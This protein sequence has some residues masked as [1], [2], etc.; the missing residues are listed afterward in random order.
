M[1]F[2]CTFDESHL[3]IVVTG[4]TLIVDAEL[5]EKPVKRTRV[6]GDWR[7]LLKNVQRAGT[8]KPAKWRSFFGPRFCLSVGIG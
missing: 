7:T 8:E 3:K 4:S 2:Q 5:L 1:T 6:L